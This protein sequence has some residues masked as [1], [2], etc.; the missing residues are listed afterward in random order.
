MALKVAAAYIRVSTEDQTELSPDSQIK[1][2]QEYAKARGYVV[3]D[4]YIFHDDGISGR[5]TKKRPG[6]NRMIAVAKTD[7][8]PFE[9]ILVWKFS[10]FARN[11]EDSI[12]FKSMLKKRGID[13]ISISEDVGDDKMSILIESLIEAMDEY[14]SV[15]LSEEVLRG[16]TEK[17][18][19]GK[20]VSTAPI[21]YKME[22]GELLVD[23]E[24]AP[25]VRSVFRE[26]LSGRAFREIAVNLNA[27]GFKT[28]R[29]NNFENRTV[30]YIIDNPVYA[31][32]LRWDTEGRGSRGHYKDG[33][34]LIVKGTHEPIISEEIYEKIKEM[35]STEKKN[36]KKFARP[37]PTVNEFALR[38]LVRCSD[39]GG[40]LCMSSTGKSLQCYRYAHGKCTVSHNISLNKINAAV[41]ARLKED[42]NSSELNIVPIEAEIQANI[43]YDRK[44]KR[45]E[46]K[47]A[48]IKDAY[49]AGVDTLEE[50]KHN[51][52]LIQ[53][54][55]D[56]LEEERAAE[57]RRNPKGTVADLK[58]KIKCAVDMLS[59]PDSSETDKNKTLKTFIDRIVF[60]RKKSQITVFYFL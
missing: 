38:S 56:A 24:T 42:I 45:E 54:T 39:C 20:P 35:R 53:S 44:I 36:A 30:Q 12:V 21:G 40:T 18:S 3:P 59:S 50:Y 16:M 23:E 57:L 47:F 52:E 19:R 31:G 34:E 60:D 43:D 17:I 5:T 28:R 25:L 14:Y 26:Y 58:N 2:I 55:I 11:R 27:K 10:R 51:K 48:R 49:Q 33:K 41:L 15:N 8:V 29:G 46:E 6:F 4:E 32:Y 13:V 7:P 1:K 9:A 37:S 22:N